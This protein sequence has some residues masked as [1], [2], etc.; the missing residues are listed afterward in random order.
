MSF[1]IFHDVH[2]NCTREKLYEAI[3]EANHLVNWWPLTAKSEAEINGI[4]NFY[5][6]DQ[7]NWFGKVTAI[8]KNHSISIEMTDSEEDWNGTHLSFIL[9]EKANGINLK[10]SHSGWKFT[11]HHFRRSSWC[12]AVLL[13][14]L[15]NYVEKGVVVPFGERA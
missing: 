10:F 2:I 4:Y 1:T 6:S 12:W 7:Y 9:E 13:L 11:N 5:F 8:K 15:K 3:T 14:G